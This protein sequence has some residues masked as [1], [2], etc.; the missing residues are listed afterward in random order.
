MGRNAP[1]RTA[2]VAA[3]AFAASPAEAHTFGADGAGFAAGFGHPLLGLDHV[4]AM[5][6][7]GAWAAQLGGRATWQIPAAFVYALVLGAALALAGLPLP[8]VE[9]GILASVLA[10]G[11]LIA[12]AVRLPAPVGMALAA[13]FALCHGHAHGAEMPLAADP[14]LYGAGFILATVAL[15]AAGVALGWA[16]RLLSPALTRAAGAAVAAA[17]LWTLL[18]AV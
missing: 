13:M 1:T 5:V 17:G 8:V 4:L 12:F 2:L 18:A 6:A 15:H 7:V 3:L 11:L 14:L 10:F 9:P 16:A